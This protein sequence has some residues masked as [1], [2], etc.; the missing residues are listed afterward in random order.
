ME[1]KTKIKTRII[2]I[3]GAFFILAASAFAIRAKSGDVVKNDA[4]KKM[5]PPV[6]EGMGLPFTRRAGAASKKAVTNKGAMK[7]NASAAKEGKSTMV[8][9]KTQPIRRAPETAT[10]RTAAER[11]QSLEIPR[12]GPADKSLFASPK[13]TVSP[14]QATP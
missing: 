9:D 2:I 14:K 7:T 4:Q 3:S 12:E 1:T 13:K 11:P 6:M 10:Q 8:F 5:R